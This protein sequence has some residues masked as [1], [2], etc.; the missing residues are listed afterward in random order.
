MEQPVKKKS[1]ALII[2]IAFMLVVLLGFWGFFFLRN[3]IFPGANSGSTPPETADNIAEVYILPLGGD[4]TNTHYIALDR[5]GNVLLEGDNLE[6]ME[7]YI[8]GQP[9]FLVSS[10]YEEAT[11]YPQLVSSTV[12]ALDGTLLIEAGP[13]AYRP[14]TGN[15]LVQSAIVD[16]ATGDTLSPDKT[17]VIDIYSNEIVHPG[18]SWVTPV[19]STQAA[20]HSSEGNIYAF[21]DENCKITKE[22]DET[23]PYSYISYIDGYYFASV[24][25]ADEY[26]SDFYLLDENFEKVFD[27]LF[28]SFSKPFAS[29]EHFELTWYDGDGYNGTSILWNFKTRQTT[30]EWNPSQQS[31]YYCT[32]KVLGFSST[33][34]GEFLTDM[35]GNVLGKYDRVVSTDYSTYGDDSEG[36]LFA[37]QGETIYKLSPEGAILAEMQI[38][39]YQLMNSIA[40]GYFSLGRDTDGNHTTALYNQ[41]FEEVIPI[42]QYQAVSSEYFN[43]QPYIRVQHRPGEAIMSI[44]DMNGNILLEDIYFFN[45]IFSDRLLVDWQGKRGMI[46]IEGNWYYQTDIP[47]EVVY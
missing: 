33:N 8:T 2:I 26:E 15:C 4:Y 3:K 18:T 21:V 13:Y 45:G 5:G 31:L 43:G 14:A 12:Y 35:Q 40:P 30:Y 44:L 36:L 20:L 16:Y 34:G 24:P 23:E 32:G 27:K 25:T 37:Q 38:S 11:P 22:F 19:S 46:D 41:N 17:A 28:Q 39:G 47:A 6:L 1:T 42:G 29:K 10:R 9:R 7:D